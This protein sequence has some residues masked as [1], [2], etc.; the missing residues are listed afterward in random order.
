MHACIPVLSHR[1]IEDL[2]RWQMI[3]PLTS[4]LEPINN[5]WN[6]TTHLGP[7]GDLTD[8]SHVIKGQKNGSAMHGV[9]E[10]LYKPFP[11]RLL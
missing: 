10:A 5:G 1:H 2:L 6:F 4:R 7:G 11:A 8:K 9:M 3:L